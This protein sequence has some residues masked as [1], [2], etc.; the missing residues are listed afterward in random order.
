MSPLL[1]GSAF[2]FWGWHEQAL[3]LAIALGVALES[4]RFIPLRLDIGQERFRAL[5]NL[6]T[7]L[8]FAFL[9]YLYFSGTNKRVW[10]MPFIKWMP[11]FMSPILLVQ[12][13][14]ERGMIPVRSLFMLIGR[15]LKG[16]HD[17]SQD[18]GI[19]FSY[20]ILPI[21]VASASVSD[22]DSEWYFPGAAI[23]S[24]WALYPER[25]RRFGVVHWLCLSLIVCLLGFWGQG[26]LPRLQYYLADIEANLY[27][28][29]TKRSDPTLTRTQ[30]GYVGRLKQSSRIIMKVTS[31]NP[32]LL[33]NAVYDV[34]DNANWHV[35]EKRFK[36]VTPE[37]KKRD[38]EK[39]TWRFV[40]SEALANTHVLTIQTTHSDDET[41]LPH[42]AGST[43]IDDLVAK[44]LHVNSLGTLKVERDAGYL[45]YSVR[46]D[47]GNEVSSPPGEADV[48]VTDKEKTVIDSFIGHYKLRGLTVGE[49]LY[50]L[51]L[52]FQNGYRYSLGSKDAAPAG[53]SPLEDF[54]ETTKSGHCEYYATATTL[55]LRALNVPARYVTGYLVNEY[56]ARGQFI[57]RQRHAHAWSVAWHNGRWVAIDSTPSTWLEDEERDSPLLQ[58][59][60]D[61]FDYTL[62]GFRKWLDEGVVGQ[63]QYALYGLFGVVFAYILIRN[64]S[65]FALTMRIKR[66]LKDTSQ[67]QGVDLVVSPFKE[68][69]GIL[70]QR[71]LPRHPWESLLEWL[72]RIRQGGFV[73]GMPHPHGAITEEELAR[74]IRLHYRL[75]FCPG[76]GN[77]EVLAELKTGVGR[78][79]E[80]EKK[81]GGAASLP[82]QDAPGSLRPTH[83]GTSPLDAP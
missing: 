37:A 6:V 7:I 35:S 56:G 67:R 73:A 14:S 82:I 29:A 78:Y 52:I 16:I 8:C 70:V 38:S 25:S 81:G 49:I 33:I 12:Y 11:V 54:L 61:V 55:I 9:I 69:E 31:N 83:K 53:V 18:R 32:L 64:R 41:T 51:P 80:K 24:L 68:L 50:R 60:R 4:A 22:Y 58:P 19:D 10:V 15:R 17:I 30:I 42:P 48:V 2:V 34:Y 20:A 40:G 77:E 74:L 44:R 3:T 59:V 39:Q 23:L 43:G 47:A 36:L 21:L 65:L 26:S 57:V 28:N 79:K 46:Y 45:A 62:F 76:P 66:P 63:A 5:V 71:T 13:Y 75:R 72:E 27:M 1:I